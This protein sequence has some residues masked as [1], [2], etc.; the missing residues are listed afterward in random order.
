MANNQK[1]T[2]YLIAMLFLA[3]GAINWL[4]FGLFKTSLFGNSTIA[5]VLYVAVGLAGLFVI[6][7]RDFYLP[8]LGQAAMPCPA[9]EDRIP[10]GASRTI[11]LSMPAGTR[12]LYWAAEPAMDELRT[13][14]DWKAAY[15]KF[16]NVGAATAGADGIVYLKVRDPQGYNVPAVGGLLQKYIAPHV[17]Y[18]ICGSDGMMSRVETVSIAEA[19]PGVEGFENPSSPALSAMGVDMPSLP[20]KNGQAPHTVNLDFGSIGASDILSVMKALQGATEAVVPSTSAS[21]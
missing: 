18:R 10:P 20:T 8:F 21:N 15:A 6:F 19:A 3:I 11:K 13:V 4:A 1:M 7:R 2:A 14:R 12:V 5:R 16:E 9:F 17:H